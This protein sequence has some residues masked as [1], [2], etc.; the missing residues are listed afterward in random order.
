MC[1]PNRCLA[2]DLSIRHKM[3]GTGCD[4]VSDNVP[5]YAWR[6]LGKLQMTSLRISVSRFELSTSLIRKQDL[7]FSLLKN[8]VNN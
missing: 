1:L 8:A 5:K 4:Q 6:N 2:M 7:F 3:E